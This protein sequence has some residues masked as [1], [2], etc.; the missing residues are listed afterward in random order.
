MS[1]ATV[2]IPSLEFQAHYKIL[3]L[4][5]FKVPHFF[6]SFSLFWLVCYF[7]SLFLMWFFFEVLINLFID[8]YVGNVHSLYYFSSFSLLGGNIFIFSKKMVLHIDWCCLIIYF[9]YLFSLLIFLALC[10]LF[11]VELMNSFVNKER[12]K[13][14]RILFSWSLIAH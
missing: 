14:P 2:H 4:I 10:D 9:N 8:S 6:R 3:N 5:S 7:V 12:R 13:I 1:S 11:Y